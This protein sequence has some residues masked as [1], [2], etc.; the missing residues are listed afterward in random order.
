MSD[1]ALNLPLTAAPLRRRS[2][3]FTAQHGAAIISVHSQNSQQTVVMPGL[4]APLQP[5][6]P[7]ALLGVPLS[8]LSLLLY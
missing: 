8:S 1:G 5:R 2:P 7:A 6:L 3:L 4:S